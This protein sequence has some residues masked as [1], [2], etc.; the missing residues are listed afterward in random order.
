MRRNILFDEVLLTLGNEICLFF[1]FVK[2]FVLWFQ[3]TLTKSLKIEW[4]TDH[5]TN[6][7]TNIKVWK[8][9]YICEEGSESASGYG[10]GSPNA[11]ADM[12]PGGGGVQI[13][14]DTGLQLVPIT[15][16]LKGLD[17]VHQVSQGGPIKKKGAKNSISGFTHGTAQTTIF[18]FQN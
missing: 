16:V 15:L 12:D 7:P 6:N 9:I 5:E 8:G 17:M 10:R 13:C 2:N 14:C 4:G 3:E 1:I 11:L 18:F